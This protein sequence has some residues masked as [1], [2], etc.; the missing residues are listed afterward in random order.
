[1]SDLNAFEIYKSDVTSCWKGLELNN[2]DVL[3]KAK[4]VT[5]GVGV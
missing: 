5:G 1:M 2:S 4:S 3:F